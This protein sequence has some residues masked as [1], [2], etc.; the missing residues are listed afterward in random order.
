[1]QPWKFFNFSVISLLISYKLVSYEKGVYIV[2]KVLINTWETLETFG[3]YMWS[4]ICHL[5][6]IYKF[7]TLC[8]RHEFFS[9]NKPR[10]VNLTKSLAAIKNYD[11]KTKMVA[12]TNLSVKYEKVSDQL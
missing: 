7:S 8:S 1:M 10:L 5:S 6:V 2:F 11:I 3:L 4:R 9:K 12:V